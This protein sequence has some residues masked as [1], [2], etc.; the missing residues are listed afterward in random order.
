MTTTDRKLVLP[1]GP[2]VPGSVPERNWLAESDEVG[3]IES[4][5]GSCGEA[6]FLGEL[7]EG[8][9]VVAGGGAQDAGRGRVGFVEW[10]RRMSIR[11]VDVAEQHGVVQP[12]VG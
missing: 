3:K 2:S 9:V 1:E 6:G 10:A 7:I 11:G 4:S 5:L 8:L 12:G